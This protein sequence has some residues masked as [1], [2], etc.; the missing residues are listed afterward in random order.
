MSLEFAAHPPQRNSEIVLAA[1]E[2]PTL[3]VELSLQEVSQRSL[4]VLQWA[5]FAVGDLEFAVDVKS[6]RL[7][8]WAMSQQLE[9]LEGD[10]SWSDEGWPSLTRRR[11]LRRHDWR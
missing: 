10:V 2:E 3:V 8:S 4:A 11:W 5:T 7:G 9:H 6:Q 1:G